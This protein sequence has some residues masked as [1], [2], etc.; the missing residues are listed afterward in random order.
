MK[1][2]KLRNVITV[3]VAITISLAAIAALILLILKIGETIQDQAANDSFVTILSA[4]IGGVCTL[5]GALV[6]LLITQIIQKRKVKADC[7][8]E[9]FLPG[10]Y[11]LAQ[12]IQ[13]RMMT[14][15]KERNIPNYQVFLKNSDKAPFLIENLIVANSTFYPKS[16]SYIEKNNL[17]CL[18][19][20]HK[21][22]V[23]EIL[24]CIKSLDD[25]SYC[26]KLF[27]DDGDVLLEGVGELK[28]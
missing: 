12:A 14:E 27:L 8:P 20:Y 2:N 13:V 5:G 3:V 26:L 23:K 1:S 7:K 24:L 10:K 22:N 19:F 4:V 28:C 18:S 17:I 16:V 15:D 21:D 9:V 25:C 6:T 11:D